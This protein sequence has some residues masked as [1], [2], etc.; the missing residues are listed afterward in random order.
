[1]NVLEHYVVKV[2]EER[3]LNPEETEHYRKYTPA[4]LIFVK[5][6]YNCYGSHGVVEEVLWKKNWEEIKKRGYDLR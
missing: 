4:D 3:Q 5:W 2:F 1:M 6:E